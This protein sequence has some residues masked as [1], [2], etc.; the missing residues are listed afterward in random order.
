M[1]TFLGHDV[2]FGRITELLWIIVPIYMYMCICIYAYVVLADKSSNEAKKVREG[3]FSSEIFPACLQENSWPLVRRGEKNF[4]KYSHV[5]L[6]AWHETQYTCKRITWLW[7]AEQPSRSW[8]PF[9]CYCRKTHPSLK[10][11]VHTLTGLMCKVKSIPSI[12]YFLVYF[13]VDISA[14][15]LLG[16]L[17][18]WMFPTLVLPLQ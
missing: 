16:F 18:V 15:R 3:C 7:G 1:N 13:E 9:E 2:S 8:L 14:F 6:T 11:P 17:P 10:H 5:I 12:L 4:N